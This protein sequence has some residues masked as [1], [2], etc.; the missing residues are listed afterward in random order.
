MP[1]VRLRIYRLFPV[2][3][4]WFG[5]GLRGIYV[6]PVDGQVDSDELLRR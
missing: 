1:D 3:A 6:D 4:V 2:C 5:F